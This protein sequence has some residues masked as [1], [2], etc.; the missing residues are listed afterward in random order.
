MSSQHITVKCKARNCSKC[1]G[2][3]C[4]TL[5]VDVNKR[6]EKP[7]DAN[8]NVEGVSGNT[9]LTSYAMT[10]ISSDLNCNT[11]LPTALLN[12]KDADGRLHNCHALLDADSQQSFITEDMAKRF[13][14]KLSECSIPVTGIN[15]CCCCSHMQG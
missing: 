14:L 5:H 9:L 3:H 15:N 10:R 2:I 6:I 13:N 8:P 1:T 12:V 4:D 11:L 7:S